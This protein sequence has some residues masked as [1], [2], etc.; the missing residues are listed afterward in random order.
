MGGIESSA[1]FAFVRD[2]N[3][4]QSFV[5]FSL[6]HASSG[7]CGTAAELYPEPLAI[8]RR[9]GSQIDNYVVNP[10]ARTAHQLCLFLW[11]TLEMH[12]AKRALCF[13]EGNIAL[14]YVGFQTM[15]GKFLFTE[16]PAKKAAFIL[17]W[18]Y[19]NNVCAF[20]SRFS[21]NHHTILTSGI[22]MMNLPP[23]CR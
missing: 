11:R 18:L 7:A 21:K 20:Q 5:R 23:F 1:I 17:D 19:I 2:F 4:S 10:P 12:A 16:A 9:A 6:N 8:G 15:T 22:G 14:S 13:I 3:V